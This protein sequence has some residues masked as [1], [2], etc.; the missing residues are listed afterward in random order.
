MPTIADK[1]TNMTAGA[2]TTEIYHWVQLGQ[3]I[4]SARLDAHLT[5]LGLAEK[6]G[7]SRAWLAKVESGHRKAEIEF[8]MRTLAALDLAFVI[9]PAT[10]PDAD[11]ELMQALR[12]AGME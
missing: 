8:L 6:A 2:T 5:Q 11:P 1:A 10:P 4:R 12:E 7:V 9:A 3:T